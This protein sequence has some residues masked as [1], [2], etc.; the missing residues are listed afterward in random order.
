MQAVRIHEYGDPENMKLDDVPTPEPGP[1]QARVKTEA[2]GVNFID[3]YQR[4]GM[5]KVP[6]PFSMGLEGAG[7][8]EAVGSDVT[9]VKVGDRVAWQGNPGSYATHTIVPADRLVPLPDGVSFEQGAAAMLQGMTAHYLIHSTYP[10]K[11]GETALIH[12]AAGG[13]GLLLVQMTK[14][15]GARAI[16]TVGNEEKA[17]LAR[18]AG[19]DEVIIY[20]QKDFVEEVKRLTGGKGVQV[21]YDGVGKDTYEKSLDCL[22]PR[23]YEVLFGA[24]S[25]PVPPLD[26]QL[27]NSKGSLFTTR[28]TLGN[29]AASREELLQ[30]GNDVLNWVKSGQ[31]K[32]RIDRTYKLSEAAEAHRAL[33][34]RQTTGKVLL[35][36]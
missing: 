29:Y 5:Y 24:A 36:G 11:A 9:L 23:G 26:L 31:L 10:L 27:L 16:G 22:A 34:G 19:A 18:E 1:G 35:K 8:V 15:V 20:T 2:S 14:L 25:G 12:A 4:S 17:K 30:R 3:I 32:L 7:T 21:V 33:N 6:L 28:P 13:V